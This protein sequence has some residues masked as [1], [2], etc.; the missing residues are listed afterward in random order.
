M[1][2]PPGRQVQA[3][4][5]MKSIRVLIAALGWAV[6]AQVQ[7]QTQLD[8]RLTPEITVNGSPGFYAVQWAQV[9]T[10]DD[11]FVV[12]ARVNDSDATLSGLTT[13]KTVKVRVPAVNDTGESQASEEKELVVP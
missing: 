8:I 2:V 13:G 4:R 9:V 10:V 6:A 11:D 7:A 5:M 12:V 3:P 1:L